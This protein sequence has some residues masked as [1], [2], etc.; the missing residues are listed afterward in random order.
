MAKSSSVLKDS[1]ID[2]TNMDPGYIIT[3]LNDELIQDA[4][5]FIKT[6]KSLEGPV[7][8]EGFYENYPGKYPYTFVK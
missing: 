6:L 5:G 3:K 2:N 4:S 1:K 8:L 7:Y